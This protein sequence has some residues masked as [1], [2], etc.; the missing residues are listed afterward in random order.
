MIR[1]YV[2]L[3][4]LSLRHNTTST[5]EFTRIAEQCVHTLL[6]QILRCDQMQ[7]LDSSFEF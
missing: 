2:I 1:G 4:F 7:S 6:S 5:F 3:K